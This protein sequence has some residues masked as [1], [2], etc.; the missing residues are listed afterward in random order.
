MFISYLY[1]NS[2]LKSIPA[3]KIN[4]ITAENRNCIN[5]NYR[6]F[7]AYTI[8]VPVI[9]FSV[10]TKIPLTFLINGYNLSFIFTF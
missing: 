6:R 7:Y 8:N 2:K 5:V 4:I 3:L 10:F 9:I 1:K